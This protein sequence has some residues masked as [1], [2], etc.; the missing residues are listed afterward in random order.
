[1][2]TH[3]VIQN[4]QEYN[5]DVIG[6]QNT[7]PVI[8]IHE[9]LIVG[10]SHINAMLA[11]KMVLINEIHDAIMALCCHGNAYT[12]YENIVYNYYTELDEL[13]GGKDYYIH[14]MHLSTSHV[15]IAKTYRSIKFSYAITH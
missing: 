14:N 8:S 15:Y 12:T 4:F 9:W 5:I 13:R 11:S 3:R 2:D 6:N 10:L 1:M 7:Y